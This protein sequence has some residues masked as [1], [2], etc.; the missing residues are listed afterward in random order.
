MSHEYGFQPY[1][2]ARGYSKRC[3]LLGLVL[4]GWCLVVSSCELNFTANTPGLSSTPSSDPV[5]AKTLREILSHCI[6][7]LRFVWV[8]P[9]LKAT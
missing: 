8:L 9:R 7:E 1:I 5:K 2:M 4:L 3:V 6:S